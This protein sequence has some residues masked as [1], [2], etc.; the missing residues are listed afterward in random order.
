MPLRVSL[1]DDDLSSGCP[2]AL[3]LSTSPPS[4]LAPRLCVKNTFFDV[5]EG[6]ND[7][8]FARSWSAPGS[9]QQYMGSHTVLSSS[10][11]APA[12]GH[13]FDGKD[14]F[15]LLRG[16][17]KLDQSPVTE[18]SQDFEFTSHFDF[19][20]PFGEDLGSGSAFIPGCASGSFQLAGA[21]LLAPSPP[22]PHAVATRSVTRIAITPPRT[23]ATLEDARSSSKMPAALAG[24]W[25]SASLPRTLRFEA[26]AK[27]EAQKRKEQQLQLGKRSLSAKEAKLAAEIN[28]HCAGANFYKKLRTLA[29]AMI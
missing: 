18:K 19:A 7:E 10:S 13:L 16:G 6:K 8:A 2:P 26:E 14:D 21:G 17:H 11:E 25:D 9:L 22:S 28:A 27:E 24:P 29:S 5:D 4:D 3:D 1:F 15:D 23:A 12:S 20:S